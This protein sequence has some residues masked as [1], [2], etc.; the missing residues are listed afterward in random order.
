MRIIQNE[1]IINTLYQWNFWDKNPKVGI[2][3]HK[4]LKKILPLLNTPEI[5]ILNGVRRCGK[6]TIL[7]QI[8]NH[9]IKK[10]VKRNNILYINLEEPLFANQNYPLFLKKIFNSYLEKFNPQKKIYLFLDEIQNAKGWENFV[11]AFFEQKAK[12]KIFASGSSSQILNSESTSVISGRYFNFL[13]K[14]LDFKE[15]LDFK[16]IKTSNYSSPKMKHLF[17]EYLQFGGFPR[18]VLENNVNNKNLILREYY[19]SIVERDIIIKH[20]IKNSI[21]LKELL[22]YTLSNIGNQIS[23]YKLGKILK[24]SD[25]VIKKY[26]KYFEN[27]YL[28]NFLPK[29]S[30][31]VSQ[32]IYNPPKVFC[33]DPG[34]CN[35]AAFKFSSNKGKLLENVIYNHLNINN[36]QFYYWKNSTEINFLSRPS[37]NRQNLYNVCWNLSENTYQREKK[38]LLLAHEH[39][40]NSSPNLIYLENELDNLDNSFNHTPA[41][42][43]LLAD[44]V[45]EFSDF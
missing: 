10:K 17:S 13:I 16:K 24:T 35:I 40:P 28:L 18:V 33:I 6:S 32:Q 25:T 20:K 9:L 22:L 23:S 11:Y 15:F 39:L 1:E 45:H 4:Y 41:L 36:K 2:I 26:L 29:F 19:N 42:E 31:K 34:I 43:L 44:T 3:R 8:I 7:K 30:Y 38:S 5:I 37:Y 14:P 21:L 27:A 12:V